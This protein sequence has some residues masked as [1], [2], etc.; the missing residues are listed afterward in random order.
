MTIGPII[1]LIAMVAAVITMT[2]VLRW[3]PKTPSRSRSTG[4][5][6]PEQAVMVHLDS[7]LVLEV[8]SENDLADLEN[9]LIQ[10]VEEND[11]GLYDGNE[12]GSADITLLLFGADAEHLFNGIEQTLRASPLC[13][14]ARV[15]IRR[16]ADGA[17]QRELRL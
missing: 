1:A 11:L 13:V 14:G 9:R 10:V 7:A 16:G 6:L 4:S 17:P 3:R 8:Y 12:R 2:V 15:T 5:P